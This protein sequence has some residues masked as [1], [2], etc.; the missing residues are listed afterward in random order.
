MDKLDPDAID[1]MTPEELAQL[2]LDDFSD[3]TPDTNQNSDE[4]QQD[5]QN[6]DENQNVTNDQNATPGE[7]QTAPKDNLK[8]EDNQPDVNKNGEPITHDPLKDTQAELTRTK[9]EL[10]E[11]Q[12]QL[13][14]L[15][16]KAEIPEIEPLTEEELKELKE[17]DPDAYVEY[18][19]QQNKREQ[20]A[21]EF[22]RS[23]EEL[24]YNE[25]LESL[26]HFLNE[27]GVNPNDK[28]ELDKFIE[29]KFKK[30]DEYLTENIIPRG[31][32]NTYTPNQIRDAWRIVY[33]DEPKKSNDQTNN[34]L[35]DIQRKNKER[36]MNKANSNISLNNIPPDGKEQKPII[37][38][39][40]LKPEEIDM[41]TP[42]QINEILKQI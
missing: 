36:A 33:G 17:T 18:V 19:L 6:S 27:V 3:T 14:D 2:K 39:E 16:K 38:L 4:N 24:F 7:N 20:K 12:Q 15:K 9:Q 41:L 34:L 23:E 13:L 40:N 1:K 26:H 28:S 37:K 5:N 11:L 10:K 31:L 25:Q 35:S 30:V 42:D 8:T 22:Q 21:Q 29:T 32:Y